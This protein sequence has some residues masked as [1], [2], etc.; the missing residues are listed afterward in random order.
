MAKFVA[1]KNK[2]ILSGKKG[3][4]ALQILNDVTDILDE[5]NIKYWLDFGTLLGVIRENRILPWDDDV[6]ISI[7]EEDVDIVENNVLPLLKKMRYRTYAR[8]LIKDAGPMKEGN[9]R[10]F[11][12]RNNRLIFFK[13]YV[14][15]DIF[16]MYRHDDSIY[17]YELKEPHALP[18][19]L[20]KEFKMIDFNGKKYRVPKDYDSY[21]T[22]HYGDW[23]TPNPEYN[24]SLD[25]G[26][27][28]AKD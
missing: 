18:Q 3:K 2:Y 11:K 8:R 14:K 12:V 16:V 21:L 1:K 9:V 23:R 17:W 6:D 7:F 28:L 5:Y 19:K 20:V 24:S 22:Y 26:R 13:G 10:S 4:I 15:L 27:T 25:N